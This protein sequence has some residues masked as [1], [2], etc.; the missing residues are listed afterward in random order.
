[1]EKDLFN[2][3]IERLTNIYDGIAFTEDD[4]TTREE[5]ER[6]LLEKPEYIIECLLDLVETEEPKDYQIIKCTVTLPIK[7]DMYTGVATELYTS[8][9]IMESNLSE[10]NAFKAFYSYE[11]ELEHSGN[12]V[13]ITEYFIEDIKEESVLLVTRFPFD[14]FNKMKEEV[15]L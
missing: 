10:A 11:T 3:L 14:K 9:K 13:T 1:M 7:F 2:N 8:C 5:I 6:F 4:L 15:K 12:Y